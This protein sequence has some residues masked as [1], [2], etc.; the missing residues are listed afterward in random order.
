MQKTFIGNQKSRKMKIKLDQ[1]FMEICSKIIK[2]NKN[3]HQWALIES[4]DM[5]QTDHYC[6]G[7]DGTENAFCFS[8]YNLEGKELWF[9]LTLNQIKQIIDGKIFSIEVKAQ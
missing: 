4:S 3:D 9:Q 5:F 6:G 2:E 1:E 8:Y 7:Y